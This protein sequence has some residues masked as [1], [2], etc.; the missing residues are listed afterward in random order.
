MMLDDDDLEFAFFAFFPTS[1]PGC[2]FWLVIVGLIAWA[3][4][5]NHHECAEQKCADGQVAQ[6]LDEQ[7][8]CVQKPLQPGQNASTSGIPADATTTTP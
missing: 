1:L 4:A 7:C 3:V 2:L 6:L 8:L 5:G